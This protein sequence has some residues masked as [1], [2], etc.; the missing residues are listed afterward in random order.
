MMNSFLM[1]FEGKLVNTKVLYKEVVRWVRPQFKV[2]HFSSACKRQRVA[3][4]RA[5]PRVHRW[6][7]Q[8]EMKGVLG[9]ALNAGFS[10]LPILATSRRNF[11]YTF[12]PLQ[13]QILKLPFFKLYKIAI[14][15]KTNSFGTFWLF[16]LISMVL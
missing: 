6:A 13:L 4:E 8:N 2:R 1:L 5:A 11:C 15:R 3:K 10:I 12:K 7:V 16:F 14:C 9:Q